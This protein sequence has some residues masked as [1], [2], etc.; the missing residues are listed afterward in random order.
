M[1]DHDDDDDANEQ[2]GRIARHLFRTDSDSSISSN[3]S[4]E[5]D[6]DD[7]TLLN[8]RERNNTEPTK[9]KGGGE[10]EER[11][12]RTIRG[13]VLEEASVGGSIA[14][15]LWPAAEQLADYL[16]HLAALQPEQLRLQQ[17]HHQQQ[18]E[19][20]RGKRP[21]SQESWNIKF[22]LRNQLTRPCAFLELGAGVG[23]TG[24]LLAANLSTCRRALLTDVAQGLVLLERN[25]QANFPPEACNDQNNNN[26]NNTRSTD[27]CDVNGLAPT[28]TNFEDAVGAVGQRLP[29]TVQLQELRW[30]NAS[31][32]AQALDWYYQQHCKR[33]NQTTTPNHHGVINENKQE[34]EPL[35]LVGSDVV[36]WEELHEPLE[37]CLFHLLKGTP[38]GTFCILAGMRRWKRD[39]K[40]FQTLGKRTQTTTHEL[41]CTCLDEFVER[42]DDDRNNDSAP[43]RN[44]C[45]IYAISMIRK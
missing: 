11:S 8:G 6:R 41:S 31:H 35:I 29:P 16:L 26:N 3:R 9:E 23:L 42:R 34:E 15:K 18:Q 20:A 27:N 43:R 7:I 38:V 10:E 45:R 14:E 32:Y 1:D 28:V 25:R 22:K 39:S 36:Y 37:H 40:F 13:I 17:E 4:T 12:R 44:I 33:S 5:R 19:N 24:L 2:E 30:G 21:F